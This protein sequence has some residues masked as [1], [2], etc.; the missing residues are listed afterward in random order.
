MSI[1]DRLQEAVQAVDELWADPVD[2]SER[3]RLVQERLALE[4]VYRPD[5]LQHDEGHGWGSG[6]AVQD[7]GERPVQQT[8]REHR[9]PQTSGGGSTQ[10]GVGLVGAATYSSGDIVRG[11]MYVSNARTDASS[12]EALLSAIQAVRPHLDEGNQ[13]ELDAATEEMHAN[14]SEADFRKLLHTIVGIASLA[15]EA[16]GPVLVTVRAL[17]D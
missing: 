17:L 11:A 4:P 7:R 5:L 15:G 2:T 8:P 10:Y 3:L 14:P 1:E 13:A 6:Q 12:F 16:G 9:G